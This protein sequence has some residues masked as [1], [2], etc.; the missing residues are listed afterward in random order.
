MLLALVF[1]C[2]LALRSLNRQSGAA[3][4]YPYIKSGML[5]TKGEKVFYDSLLV[6]LPPSCVIAIK[7]R[8]GDLISVKKG[9]SKKE[10]LIARSK[11]Q[12][13][14]IDFVLCRRDSMEVV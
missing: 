13:K 1:L 2:W 3:R 6:S 7:V 5:L 10:A 14:H 11:I 12:Q 4:E 9:L 8:L